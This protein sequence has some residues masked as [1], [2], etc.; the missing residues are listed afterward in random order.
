MSLVEDLRIELPWGVLY[1][2][3]DAFHPSDGEWDPVDQ[4]YVQRHFVYLAAC[5]E[6]HGPVLVRVNDS[7]DV[8]D[9][10]ALWRGVIEIPSG[11]MRIGDL[12]DERESRYVDVNLGSCHIALF[13][14]P[15]QLPDLVTIYVDTESPTAFAD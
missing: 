1:V 9:I 6:Q 15:I 8:P 2:G 14:D 5:H 11:R 10:G 7:S 13:G 4:P 3:D 12:L